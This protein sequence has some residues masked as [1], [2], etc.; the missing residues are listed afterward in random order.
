[1]YRINKFKIVFVK[2]KFQNTIE[3]NNDENESYFNILKLYIIIHYIVFIR[4][5]DNT[6][7]FDILYNEIIYKFLLKI[8]YILINK[9]D[10]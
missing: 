1:M 6:Q 4:L 10:N 5:Y 7:N 8:F 2:Y 3:N 9:I